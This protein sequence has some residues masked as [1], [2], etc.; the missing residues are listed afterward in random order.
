ME[1]TIEAGAA[2]ESARRLINTINER[3][4]SITCQTEYPLHYT[5]DDGQVVS[6]WIDLLLE[7]DEGFILIDHK[8]SPR[9]RSDWEEIALGYS[10]QLDAY[11]EGITKA[12]GKPVVSRWIHFAVTGGLVELCSY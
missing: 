10:G 3:F 8:A 11:A 12:T 7:T 4:K 6:G 9:A 2:D 1:N 5:T